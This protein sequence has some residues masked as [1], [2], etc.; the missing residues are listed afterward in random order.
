NIDAS[1]MQ[2][3]L[4]LHEIKDERPARVRAVVPYLPYAR[5]DKRFLEGEAVSAKII[6]GMIARAGCDELIT[7]D[8][9]FL[10]RAGNFEY[11]GLKIK[12]LTMGEELLSAAKKFCKNPLII[13]PDE[14]ARYL[15]E[16]EESGRVMKKERGEYVKKGSTTFREARIVRGVSDVKRRD[17]IIIDD[18]VASGGTMLK[19]A[20]ACRKLG[21]GTIVCCATHGLFLGDAHKKLL[22]EGAKKV[23]SSNTIPHETSRVSVKK[24]IEAVI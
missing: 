22:R 10:K 14:G 5:Q 17:I 18:M 12:N 3:F 1:L 19:A 6:C 24:K 15:V 13:S 9:H 2:L 11:E 20:R 7:F 8:C 4:A 16:K 21:A 23:I